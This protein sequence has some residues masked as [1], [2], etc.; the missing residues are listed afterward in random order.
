VSANLFFFPKVCEIKLKIKSWE[1]DEYEIIRKISAA[2]IEKY[3]KYWTD[4]HGLMAVAV[5]LDPRLKMTIL[6]ACY[7]ALFGEQHAEIYMIEA[8]ELLSDLMKQYHVK[9]QDFVSTSSS[10]ASSSA[11]QLV[12][13]LFLKPLQQIRRLLALLEV[14]MS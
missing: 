4:M 11:M 14:R 13:C 8:H 10:G 1:H 7:I 2:M 9:E 12:C 3:D 6:H 5:I